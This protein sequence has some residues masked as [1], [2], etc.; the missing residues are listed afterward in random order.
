MTLKPSESDFSNFIRFVTLAYAKR[1][2]TYD[3][4]LVIPPTPSLISHLDKEKVNPYKQVYQPLTNKTAEFTWWR[5]KE[6]EEE[7]EERVEVGGAEGVD[8]E[9]ESSSEEKEKARPSMTDED[10]NT[11]SRW[12]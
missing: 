6:E 12:Q 7:E 3:G 10:F 1:W 11:S 8:Q 4:I 5:T 2:A 9:Q